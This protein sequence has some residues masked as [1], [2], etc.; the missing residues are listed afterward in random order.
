MT[1]YTIDGAAELERSLGRAATALE[2]IDQSAGADAADA[3][4]RSAAQRAPRATGRLANS[5]RAQANQVAVTAP[6]AG[7]VH[8]GTRYM[9]GRPWLTDTADRG[10]WA[11]AYRDELD[12][13]TNQIKGA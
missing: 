1:E 6:Y 2:Q 11:Q 10:D 5:H 7:Y 9:H 12:T 8:Y 13:I 3:M 4:A